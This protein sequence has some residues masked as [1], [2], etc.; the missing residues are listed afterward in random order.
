MSSSGSD[1]AGP[2]AGKARGSLLPSGLVYSVLALSLLVISTRST[3]SSRHARDMYGP[4]SAFDAQSWNTQLS[5]AAGATA[6][7]A[8][9]AS[10]LCRNA[11]YHACAIY[12]MRL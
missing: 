8:I 4:S 1:P 7:P 10:L 2:G 11:R 12:Q 5:I 6:D 9:I 3:S